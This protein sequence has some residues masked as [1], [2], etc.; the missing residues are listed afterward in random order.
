VAEFARYPTADHQAPAAN[1]IDHRQPREVSKNGDAKQ[2]HAHQDQGTTHMVKAGGN[3][4]TEGIPHQATNTKRQCA[5]NA[6][7]VH[8]GERRGAGHH[9]RQADKTQGEDDPVKGFRLVFARLK[10][11]PGAQRQQR[12]KQ[13]SHIA[14]E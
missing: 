5:L 11:I 6:A 14:K 10:Y 4:F 8:G 7:V 3:S 13:K 12:R 1:G 9:Q 2:E